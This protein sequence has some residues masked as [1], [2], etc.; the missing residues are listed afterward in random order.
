MD[1]RTHKKIDGELIAN[2]MKVYQI[3]KEELAEKTELS[4]QTINKALKGLPSRTSTIDKIA[5]A[6][7]TT[8]DNISYLD[9]YKDLSFLDQDDSNSKY[10]FNIEEQAIIKEAIEILRRFV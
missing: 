7:K 9:N 1:K 3:S 4:I 10:F 8:P 5:E 2:L 6:L